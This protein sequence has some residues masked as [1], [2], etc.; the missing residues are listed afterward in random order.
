M[1]CSLLSLGVILA[2]CDD[3]DE[4]TNTIT[5]LSIT[6]TDVPLLPVG[7]S[8]QFTATGTY[9]NG[10]T[11]DNTSVAD[12]ITS[13]SSVVTIDATGVAI[14]RATGTAN[15]SAALGVIS[16]TVT[17]QVQAEAPP[18]PTEPED[19]TPDNVCNA[20]FCATD[21]AL[22]QTCTNFLAA[23]IATEPTNEEEC[24]G[25]ALWICQHPD[26]DPGLVCGT[27][28]CGTDPDLQQQCQ[29]FMAICIN[30]TANSEECAG[31]MLFFCRPEE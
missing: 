20:E 7:E 9:S 12:W 26:A 19:Y 2:G 30:E 8:Q 4:A 27:G 15:I 5:G 28:A 31:A 10:T 6:P 14:T 29:D 13:D 11:Q 3:D 21:D 17:M 23:C 25:G 24:V 22:S 18:P 1:F 16:N